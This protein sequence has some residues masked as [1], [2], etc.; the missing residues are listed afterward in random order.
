M[1]EKNGGL[2]LSRENFRR[3]EKK[4]GGELFIGIGEGI[5]GRG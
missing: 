5:Y 3:G 1:L 4:G 2:K